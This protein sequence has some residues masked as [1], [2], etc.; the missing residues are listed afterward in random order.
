MNEKD[1]QGLPDD[2]PADL[3]AIRWLIR[4]VVPERYQEEF[5]GDLI[6]EY[7]TLICPQWGPGRSNWWLWR[8]VLGSMIPMLRLRLEEVQMIWKASIRSLMDYRLS[9]EAFDARLVLWVCSL[10]G[11]ALVPL[12]FLALLRNGGGTGDFLIGVGLAVVAVALAAMLGR[13]LDEAD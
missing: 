2:L 4:L 8:Q 6:E 11:V 13:L 10:F 3:R 12:A 5:L 7:E 9:T 1:E